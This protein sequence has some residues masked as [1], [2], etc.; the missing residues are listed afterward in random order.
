MTVKQLAQ[1][2]S[3]DILA[4]NGGIDNEVS[5]CYC[6]DLLSWVM[7]HAEPGDA[8]ITVQTHA[9]VVAV[10]MLADIACIII[11]ELVAVDNDTIYRADQ[12]HIPILTGA[13]SAYDIAG[14]LYALGI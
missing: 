8:W 13:Q 12:H 7:A 11:P 1:A 6:C 3:L 4:G 5:G 10:A 9:N 14:R 2:L